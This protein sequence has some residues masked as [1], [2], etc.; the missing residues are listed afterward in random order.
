MNVGTL[1]RWEVWKAG[2]EYWL[3]VAGGRHDYAGYQ[4]CV[5]RF[6]A[7]TADANNVLRFFRS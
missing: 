2:A 1:V 4:R 5:A 7:T 3:E 6:T